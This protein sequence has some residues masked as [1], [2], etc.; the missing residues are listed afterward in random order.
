MNLRP[1]CSIVI[2]RLFFLVRPCVYSPHTST[3]FIKRSTHIRSSLELESCLNFCLSQFLPARACISSDH[4]LHPQ[5]MGT[6]SGFR[7]VVGMSCF[8]MFLTGDGSQFSFLVCLALTLR[9]D[10]VL[11]RDGLSF[12]FDQCITFLTRAFVWS[13][14]DI[15]HHL[16][17]SCNSF[18]WPPFQVCWSVDDHYLGSEQ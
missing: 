14:F 1:T 8:A 15:I 10:P 13:R 6:S 12:Q 3:R 18:W 16:L 4:K 7:F 9:M 5:N 17:P 11:W 2:R